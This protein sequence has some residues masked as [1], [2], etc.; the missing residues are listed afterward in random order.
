M[1]KKI[2]IFLLLQK[3]QEN[4]NQPWQKKMWKNF[5]D[6]GD[7]DKDKDKVKA[8]LQI[9]M[10]DQGDKNF[11]IL[12]LVLSYTTRRSA[13]MRKYVSYFEIW[14]LFLKIVSYPILRKWIGLHNNSHGDREWNALGEALLFL[15]RK[16]AIPK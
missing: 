2:L 11:W 16:R 1:Q 10:M 3:T 9:K 12:F 13:Q 15:L 5:K 8:W 6:K 7:R 4:K 14:Y